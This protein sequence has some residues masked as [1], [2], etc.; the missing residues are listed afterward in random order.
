MK[1]YSFIAGV[2]VL[3]VAILACS[4]SSSKQTNEDSTVTVEQ[5]STEAVAMNTSLET[6]NTID[7]PVSTEL[8]WFGFEEGYAKSVKEGKILLVD[9]YTDWC[10]WC[11]RSG[12]QPILVTLSNLSRHRGNRFLV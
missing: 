11:C 1:K 3:A 10:G 6:A 4:N 5:T 12:H 2:V 7:E 8:K 9:A